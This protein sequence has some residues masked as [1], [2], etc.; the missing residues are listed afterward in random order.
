MA[1]ESKLKHLEF[2]EATVNRMSGTSFLFKGWSVTLVSAL[3]ALAAKEANK[4]YIVI[5]YVPVLIFWV[6]DGYFLSQ[7]RLFRA[8]YDNVRKLPDDRIDFSMDTSP[9]KTLRNSWGAAFFSG[10]LAFFYLSFVALMLGVMYL[11]K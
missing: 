11:I 5:A 4:K 6:I 10:T 9:F 1:A 8:L 2:V 3:F 7:E